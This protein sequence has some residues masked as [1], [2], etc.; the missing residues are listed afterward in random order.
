MTLCRTFSFTT[1][2]KTKTCRGGVIEK[3]VENGDIAFDEIVAAFSEAL[4]K[5]LHIEPKSHR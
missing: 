3:L 5:G 2:K 1:G 4:A